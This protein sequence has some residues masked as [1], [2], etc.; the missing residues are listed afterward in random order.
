MAKYRVLE[1]L[2]SLST[3]LDILPGAIIEIE[4]EQAAA[5]LLEK[6][7]VAPAVKSTGKPQI[8]VVEEKK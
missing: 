2:V 5:I 7:V 1:S 4:D 8:E 6:N 3:G